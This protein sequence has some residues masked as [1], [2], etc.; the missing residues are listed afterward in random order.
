MLFFNR[1]KVLA[2][3]FLEQLQQRAGALA[4]EHDAADL[5]HGLFGHVD[6]TL[7]LRGVVVL[8]VHVVEAQ[9]ALALVLVGGKVEDVCKLRFNG[10]PSVKKFLS[11]L[12]RKDGILSINCLAGGADI[13]YN[14]VNLFENEVVP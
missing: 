5:I 7:L 1:L 11:A 2:Q 8:H 14:I 6:E 10:G 9:G 3:R 13:R 12:N 4:R